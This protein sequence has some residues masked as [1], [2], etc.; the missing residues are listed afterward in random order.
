MSRILTRSGYCGAFQTQGIF[1]WSHYS[2]SVYPKNTYPH[3][4]TS[5]GLEDPLVWIWMA[6]PQWQPGL[7]SEQV[8][9]ALGLK[10]PTI[11]LTSVQTRFERQGK[12]LNFYEVYEYFRT[13]F[14]FFESYIDFSFEIF[15]L[16]IFMKFMSVF[17]RFFFFWV[18][19]WFFISYSMAQRTS[20][21]VLRI[22]RPRTERVNY[23]DYLDCLKVMNFLVNVCIFLL[24]KKR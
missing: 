17:G 12:F 21:E 24:S 8:K 6:F 15:F 13:I 3:P 5:L 20:T 9:F 18:I 4:K 11:T 22:L 10:W 16:W 2:K 7:S 19:Y 23:L 1:F 14:L